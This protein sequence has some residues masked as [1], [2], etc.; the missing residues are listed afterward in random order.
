MD[1]AEQCLF[2]EKVSDF[3]RTVAH[4]ISSHPR[5]HTKYLEQISAQQQYFK[6]KPWVSHF[7]PHLDV[8]HK[9]L[10]QFLLHTSHQPVSLPASPPSV[11]LSASPE[12]ASVTM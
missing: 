11:S 12:Y 7:V 9:R 4:L 2:E 8:V 10:E 3:E 5:Q 1:P 6:E